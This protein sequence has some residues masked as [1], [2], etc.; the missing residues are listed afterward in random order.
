MYIRGV[1]GGAAKGVVNPLLK[2]E[3][4]FLR[5]RLLDDGIAGEL[6]KENCINPKAATEEE[7]E[8]EAITRKRKGKR[9]NME[10]K[11]GGIGGRG[12]G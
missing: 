4:P 5:I 1:R 6:I 12:W 9:W 11:E 10:R 2:S 3:I 8:E 7:H